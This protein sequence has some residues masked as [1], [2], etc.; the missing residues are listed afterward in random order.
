MNNTG[1]W[2]KKKGKKRSPISSSFQRLNSSLGEYLMAI[3]T[4]SNSIEGTNKTR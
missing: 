3:K 1:S 4:L 2:R